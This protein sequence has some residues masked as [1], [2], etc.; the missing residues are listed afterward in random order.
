[1]TDDTI[2]PESLGLTPASLREM[3]TEDPPPSP[4]IGACRGYRGTDIPAVILPVPETSP[5]MEA[6][7]AQGGPAERYEWVEEPLEERPDVAGRQTYTEIFTI[8]A[9]GHEVP[10]GQGGIHEVAQEFDSAGVRIRGPLFWDDDVPVPEW[11]LDAQRVE[12]A[13]ASATLPDL[14]AHGV[15]IIQAEALAFLRTLPSN[16][17]DMVATDGPYSSGGQFRGDRAK[18]PEEKYASTG[19][20]F[21]DEAFT[22]CGDTRDQRSFLLW[23][24]LWVTE[25]HRVLKPGGLLVSFCDWRQLGATQDYIQAGG[26]VLR[27]VGAWSKPD[28]GARPRWGA[29]RQSAE[30]FAWGSKAQMV[31]G[32]RDGTKWDGCY[33]KGVLTHALPDDERLHLTAKPVALMEDIIRVCPPGGL[34]LDPFA[35]AGTTLVA[36][37]R[38]GRRAIGCEVVESYAHRARQRIAVEVAG[39]VLRARKGRIIQETGPDL[40]E[41]MTDLPPLA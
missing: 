10:A 22:F 38:N 7:K 13:R 17:V 31:E 5:L 6:I 39:G 37:L 1:M 35:G 29:F 16:S 41:G 8:D 20:A 25:C 33:G 27:G 15:A 40:F 12:V 26:I 34:I 30:F 24:T 36:A 3:F 23:A 18:P 9:G 2:P 19:T 28:D 32:W 4:G 14:G 11:L 21:Q